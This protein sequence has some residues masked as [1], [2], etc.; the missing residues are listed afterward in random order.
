MGNFF[1][2]LKAGL[3]EVLR[4][5]VDEIPNEGIIR[6]LYYFNGERLAVVG[7][8]ALAEVLVHK[9]YDFEKPALLRKGVSIAL[10]MGLFLAEGENHKVNLCLSSMLLL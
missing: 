5:W 9:S 4:A 1:P 2:I 8:T 3:G 10:G 6:Y 7:P